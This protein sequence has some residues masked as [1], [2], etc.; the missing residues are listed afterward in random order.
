MRFVSIS[1][2]ALSGVV[3]VPPSKSLLHRGLVCAALSG[4]LSRCVLPAEDALSDD[5][6][7]TRD[8]LRRLL[9]GG[10]GA[11]PLHLFCGESGTTLR[12]LVPLLAARGVEAVLDGS[13]RLPERPM[14]EYQ[15]AFQGRGVALDFLVKGRVLPLRI[16]GRLAPGRFTLPGNVSSQYISGLLLALPLL[17]GDSDIILSSPLES[18]PYVDMTLD[19]MRHFGVT[20]TRTA[21]GCHVPGRQR[22]Q[23]ASAYVP[24]PD[25]SQA[26]FWR[27]AAFL[28]QGVAVANLPA[29]TS[30]GDSAFAGMLERL[31][32]DADG[33]PRVFDVSQTPDLVP[34]LAAA[35]ASARGETRLANAARLRL[36][37]SDRLASTAAMLHSFGVAVEALPDGLVV[38]GADRR[39][40]GGTVDGCRDHRIVMAAAM[41]A[42]RADG[43]TT[44]LGSDAVA[45]SYPTFFQDFRHAGGIAHEFD[46]G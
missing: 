25:F 14:A 20:A 36:K 46:M 39:L 29:R 19:V 34:A 6:R 44:I 28:G 13:G 33:E 26:A 43:A 15:T 30:Q 38:H 23:A 45:K 12:L 9:G 8:C 35:A 1:P 11:E 24:E 7:V 3:E 32:A 17:E 40:R 2:C 27:L 4:D 37:E 10:E 18:E 22:C 21:A 41:L 5:I 16:R 42:T 31:A